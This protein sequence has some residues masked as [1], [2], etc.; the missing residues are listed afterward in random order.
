MPGKTLTKTKTVSKVLSPSPEEGAATKFNLFSS[1]FCVENIRQK[2]TCFYVNPPNSGF[3]KVS[4]DM[5]KSKKD[6]SSPASIFEMLLETAKSRDRKK[7][8][9]L[10]APMGVKE[11][12]DE[13]SIEI[14][15][16]TCRGVECKLC[17]KACPTN[18]LYWRAGEIGI[19]GE[20]CVYCGACVLN[21]IVDDCIKVRRKRPDGTSE[22]FN[23][24][25]DFLAL[26]NKICSF[27]RKDLIKSIF[28]SEEEYFRRYVNR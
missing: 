1:A 17:I 18:A 2:L 24:P 19:T 23:K 12:F 16:K 21:C 15:M 8:K 3:R 10:L 6:E 27:R 5:P 26:Q 22:V 14:D 7:R 28:S 25:N 4:R 20:L 9:E 11:F 13:G